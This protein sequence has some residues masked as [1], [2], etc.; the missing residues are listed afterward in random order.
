MT[1]NLIHSSLSCLLLKKHLNLMNSLEGEKKKNFKKLRTKQRF[2][3]LVSF[4]RWKGEEGGRAR[5]RLPQKNLRGG[6]SKVEGNTNLQA[7]QTGQ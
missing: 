1:I 7:P 5:S 6:S 3:L 2:G 4:I